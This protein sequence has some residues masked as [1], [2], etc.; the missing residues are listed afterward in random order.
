LIVDLR[1]RDFRTAKR[2]QPGLLPRLW[3]RLFRRIDGWR[4][5]RSFLESGR[6]FTFLGFNRFSRFER[7]LRFVFLR[8][9]SH[10]FCS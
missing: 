9:V 2:R 10:E 1:P 6:K 7:F 3:L 8:F 5:P 4:E